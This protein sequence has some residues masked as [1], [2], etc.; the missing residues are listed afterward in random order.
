MQTLF[1]SNTFE[2]LGLIFVY[3]PDSLSVRVGTVSGLQSVVSR[4]TDS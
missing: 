3:N 1:C 2:K 4:M